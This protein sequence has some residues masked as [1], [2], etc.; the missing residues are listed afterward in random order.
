MEGVERLAL[1]ENHRRIVSAV[2]R[3]VEAMCDQVL[4]WMVQPSSGLRQRSN[5][6]SKDQTDEMRALVERLRQELRSVQMELTVDRV[7]Q[8]RSRAI[9]AS[10][11]HCRVEIE[12]VLTPG[13]R[14]YGPLSAET[15]LALDAKFARLLS[16]LHAMS[17]VVEHRFQQ[18][19][20]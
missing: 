12:E 20:P 3:H 11:S 7:V 15:E 6:L 18:G 14:G 4:D 13:L 10:I 17:N 8:S 9:A 19:A 2:L 16:S 1:P 5:D